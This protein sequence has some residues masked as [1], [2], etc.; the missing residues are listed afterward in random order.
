MKKASAAKAS[1]TLWAIYT[2]ESTEGQLAGKSYNSHHSQEDFL[3]AWVKSQ[4]GEVFAAYSDTESGTKLSRDGLLRLFADAQAGSFQ[5]AVAYDVDR[6]CRSIEIYSIMKRMTRDT[7][8]TFESAT[9]RFNDDAEGELMEVQTAAF[10]Q[11]YSRLVSRKVK[12]KRA[13]MLAKG[14]WPGGHTP[15]GY[16]A[17]EKKLVP[18]PKE[19]EVVRRMFEL[20]TS[21]L[22][23]RRCANSCER[24]GSRTERAR[25]GRT[26]PSSRF[27]V[28]GSTSARFA[29]RR[30]GFR[31]CT[32]RSWIWRCLSACRPLLRPS[33]A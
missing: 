1:T 3:R 28:V 13:Q 20:F 22:R 29:P 5:R 26:H 12:I 16:M 9:Q 18:E 7:G 32:P 4:G 31:A 19:A 33:G 30:A 2:R 23:A 14:M 21:I 15:Y 17:V 24:S 8:V 27:F 6:W 10:A 11:Y 25:L